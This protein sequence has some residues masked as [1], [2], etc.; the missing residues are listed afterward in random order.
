MI[1]Y[2]QLINQLFN[3]YFLIAGSYNY[4]IHY[5]MLYFIIELYVIYI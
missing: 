5:M 4:K 1:L 3:L 2:L